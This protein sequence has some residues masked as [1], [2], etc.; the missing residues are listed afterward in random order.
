M[1][2]GL[3]SG[4]K[5]FLDGDSTINLIFFLVNAKGSKELRGDFES[6]LPSEEAKKK[7]QKFIKAIQENLDKLGF[8]ESG[9]PKKIQKDLELSCERAINKE[10]PNPESRVELSAYRSYIPDEFDTKDTDLFNSLERNSQSIL[11][12]CAIILSAVNAINQANQSSTNNPSGIYKEILKPLI[13]YSQVEKTSHKIKKYLFHKDPAVSVIG[14]ALNWSSV[15]LCWFIELQNSIEKNKKSSFYSSYKSASPPVAVLELLL[16]FTGDF[17]KNENYI[18]TPLKLIR[19]Q[20]TLYAI[21][22]LT[23]SA[24]RSLLKENS[25]QDEIF[26][27]VFFTHLGNVTLGLALSLPNNPIKRLYENIDKGID[28]IKLPNIWGL[29]LTKSKKIE[30]KQP[31]EEQKKFWESFLSK[32]VKKSEEID[33]S[34]QSPMLS[35]RT[36]RVNKT[37]Q[38]R[39]E[40][41]PAR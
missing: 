40:I 28:N 35:P 32:L 29:N 16:G 33:S 18:I 4:L 13:E 37:A 17:T 5:R 30:I 22:A 34:Q 12:S 26:E 1:R 38:A 2:E 19:N 14:G 41:Q 3:D 25:T 31:S 15:M 39:D 8:F 36:R 23:Y 20:V 9:D 24:K 11:M 10:T 21:T 7:F 27:S 6:R